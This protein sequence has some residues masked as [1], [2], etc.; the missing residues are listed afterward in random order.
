MHSSPAS[1]DAGPLVPPWRH[2]YD[3][4][5]AGGSTIHVREWGDPSGPLVI[6]HHGTPSSS[7]SI[8]GGWD[9]AR[10]SGIRLCSFDRPGYARSLRRPGRVVADAGHW[11]TA[12]ADHLGV[13]RFVSVGTSGG[14][15]FAA[16]AA[17]LHPDR[18]SALGIIVGI[19]PGE[20]GFDPATDM[21]EATVGE[22]AAARAGEERLRAFI[23]DLGSV[24]D[25]LDEWLAR[26]P[27]SDVEVS[28]RPEVKTEEDLEQ[29]EWGLQGIDGWVDDELAL[30]QHGWGLRAAQIVAPTELLFGDADVFV[31]PSH[32][33]QWSRLIPHARLTWVPG[34][35]HYLRDH[36]T[37]LLRRL[38]GLA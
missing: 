20:D 6:W 9:A 19:A 34:G 3:L 31:P 21:V 7:A 33:R 35:G 12:I 27:E 22:I 25:A 16:A 5:V 38:A 18:V 10:D 26:Y 13:E 24:D 11:A 17:A 15:P 28:S 1:V 14:G 4:P 23:D 32:A 36:E 2:S 37:P 30:F 8:P 29:Q